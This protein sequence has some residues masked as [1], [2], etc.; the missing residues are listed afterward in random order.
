MILKMNKIPRKYPMYKKIIRLVQSF[1]RSEH[2][3]KNNWIIVIETVK[4]PKNHI[5]YLGFKKEIL[6]KFNEL[7]RN[8]KLEH[9]V[10]KKKIIVSMTLAVRN[11]D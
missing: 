7:K 8:L 10:K 1:G 3:K 6:N 11:F 2:L 5:V 9:S 4:R